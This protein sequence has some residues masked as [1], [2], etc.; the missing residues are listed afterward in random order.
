MTF[1]EG[2]SDT[3]G[4]GFQGFHGFHGLSSLCQ[5]EVDQ[6]SDFESETEWIGTLEFNKPNFTKLTKMEDTERK[7]KRCVV[8]VVV[9]CMV[10]MVVI[11]SSSEGAEIEV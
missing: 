9:L 11:F 8:V 1:V 7:E 6:T 3:T 5:A 10:A 4:S 2:I